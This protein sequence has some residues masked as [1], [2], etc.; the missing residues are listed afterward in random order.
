MAQQPFPL[1]NFQ[2]IDGSP[3]AN[4]SVSIQLNMNGAANNTQ[5]NIKPVTVTLDSSGNITGSPVFWPT[6]SISPPNTY[7]IYIVYNKQGQRVA[8]PN[9]ITI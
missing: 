8:G 2:N 9:K 7:Y 3:V 6:A 4:G 5:L 1:T